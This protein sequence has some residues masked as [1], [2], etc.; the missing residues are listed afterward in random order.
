MLGEAKAV[1][2]NWTRQRRRWLFDLRVPVVSSEMSPQES[3]PQCLKP[4][5]YLIDRS[6]D[7]LVETSDLDVAFVHEFELV[8]SR[9][10]DQFVIPIEQI[11]DTG[12]EFVRFRDLARKR[13]APRTI[14]GRN[15]SGITGLKRKEI[16]ILQKRRK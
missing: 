8:Q 1:R 10:L 11:F 7:H 14:S 2:P 13:V 16:A 15:A 3:P 6:L 4:P 12:A 9:F 5:S